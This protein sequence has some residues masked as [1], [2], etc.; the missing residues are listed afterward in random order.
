MLRRDGI[1]RA[2]TVVAMG[3]SLVGCSGSDNA[4]ESANAGNGVDPTNTDT[5]AN[6]SFVSQ[7]TSVIGASSDTTEPASTDAIT[8]TAP[9]DTEPEM[10]SS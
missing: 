9:D 7:V 3:F 2:I 10:I 4:D 5:V 1:M 6:D 8:V